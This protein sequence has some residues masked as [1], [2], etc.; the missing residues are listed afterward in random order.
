MDRALKSIF[1][2]YIVFT[3][4]KRGKCIKPVEEVIDLTELDIFTLGIEKRTIHLG[5][6]QSTC[7]T[8]EALSVFNRQLNILEETKQRANPECASTTVNSI[9]SGLGRQVYPVV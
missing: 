4:T 2:I 8:R 7:Y 5:Q 3:A 6:S 1:N 9:N